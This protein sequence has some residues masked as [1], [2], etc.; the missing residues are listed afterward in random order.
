MGCDIHAVFQKRT[1][2][3]WEDVPTTW[4]EG[5]HYFLFSVLAGVRN[6]FG[7][8]GTPTYD[9]VKPISEPRGL[10]ADFA[11]DGDAHP[12]A[13]V[14]LLGWHARYHQDNE[15]IARWMGDHSHSWLTADEILA[16]EKAGGQRAVERTGVLSLEAY[17]EWDKVSQPPAWC[18]GVMGHGILVS[19]P[20][21]I[22]E[23]T[24]HV[25]VKWIRSQLDEIG[26]FFDEVRRLKGEHG[27]VRMVFGF[28]S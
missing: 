9:P 21:E 26:Y 2:A 25:N 1:D 14:E 6:G 15:P 4:D 7:F 10:P 3:G 11:M 22:N 27:E 19:V 20:G 24:T 13:S 12:V 17:R 18:G 8:A 28:D 23:R 5:R 16:Y